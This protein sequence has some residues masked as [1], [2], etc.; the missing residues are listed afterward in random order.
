MSL[1]A[2]AQ[3]L[4]HQFWQ[5]MDNLNARI[6]TILKDK[7]TRLILIPYLMVKSFSFHHW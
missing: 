3:Y 7:E 6:D 2:R 4:D 5:K 1:E